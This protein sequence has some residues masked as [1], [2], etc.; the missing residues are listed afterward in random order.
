MLTRV[1]RAAVPT[2]IVLAAAIIAVGVHRNGHTLGD[3]FALYLRQ[4]SSIF[5]GNPS[6][7]VANNRFSVLNSP[8]G[9]SPIAY[10][11]GW[12]LLLS[13][14]VHQWGLDYDKLKLVEVAVFCVSLVLLHGVV[15]RRTNRWIA[16]GVM[17]MIGLAPIYLGH[18]DQL[19]TEFPH[20]AAV[21][22]V[23]WWIDR[24]VVRAA[25]ADRPW[26]TAST[27]DLV[28]VGVLAAFAFNV[29]RE[30]IVFFGVFAAAQLVDLARSSWPR[31]RGAGVRLDLWKL[32]TPH[33]AMITGIVV[34]QLALPSM[35]IPDNGGG[36]RYV[37]ERIGDSFAVISN[38]L[39]LGKH[40][41]VGVALVVAAL[42]G[43]FIACQRDPV[44]NVPLAALMVLSMIAVSTHFR[45]VDRYYLQVTPFIVF[46]AAYLLMSA[47][48][49]ADRS[50]A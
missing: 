47:I 28:I 29:R 21:L 39:G 5:E 26:L 36:M 14:F 8:A 38:Q 43:A 12:P 23:M 10:P 37:P 7:V 1:G 45:L 50:L 11:W 6:E 2:V 25:D 19:L 20:L 17:A 3:D 33:L 15:R 4:A 18:T 40:D 30:A 35:L 13:P 16:A 24:I 49:F 9:F 32:A 34:I 27:R 22:V 41:A 44:R 42:I 48:D 31:I 46:Y